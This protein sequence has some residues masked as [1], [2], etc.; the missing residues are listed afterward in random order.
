MEGE[1]MTEITRRMGELE[2]QIAV[3]TS[4]T[5]LATLYE[6]YR[7][8]GRCFCSKCGIEL[9]PLQEGTLCNYCIA[10]KAA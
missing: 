2:K 8:L 3:E 5:K 9:L 10:L 6:E 1:P 4:I 7:Q